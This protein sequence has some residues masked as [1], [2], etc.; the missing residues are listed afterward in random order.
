MKGIIVKFG[1]T[2]LY[3]IIGLL[4]LGLCGE[5]VRA[6]EVELPGEVFFYSPIA[7]SFGQNAVWTNPAALG[8]RQLG[9]VLIF[10]HRDKRLIRDF[11]SV[12]TTRALG[13]AY[14]SIQGG[15]SPDHEEFIFALGGGKRTG[16]GI[17]YRYIR[18]GAGYL[19][20]R[21]LWTASILFQQTRQLS[22][23]ARAENLNRGRINGVRSDIRFVYGAA[24]RAYKDQFTVTFDVDMTQKESFRQ[25]DF[26]T[27]IEL[28]PMRGMFIY[29]DVDNHSRFNLGFRLN[30]RS[31]YVG[32]R[33]EF[34]SSCKS[35]LSTTYVGTVKG[36]QA[37]LIKPKR[38]MLSLG[39]DGELPE[40][41]DIPF[42]GRRP[43]RFF[44]YIA[45]I[46][47]AADDDQIDRLFLHIKTLRCGLGKAEE[48]IEALRYFKSRNK[49]V[50]A[51]LSDPNNLG[52][53]VAST[54]DSVFIPPVSAV[55][56]T[57]LRVELMMYKG[58]L[59]K[60]G[61]ELELE[62]VDEYK[63]AAEPY[64]FEEPTEANR[65]Q[66]NRWLEVMYDD[67]T[68]VIAE[69]RRL[70]LDS[71]RNLIDSAPLTSLNAADAGLVDSLLYLDEAYDALTGSSASYRS[72][73]MS[74]YS[75]Y[76][77]PVFDDTWG[78][79]PT[80]AIVIA[81][82]GITAG[83]SGTRIGEH[84]MIGAVRRCRFDPGIK[85]VLLRINSPGGDALAADLLWHEID[86]LAEKKP[87]VIS[88][89]N[90]AASGGYYI[91]AIE[92][93]ILADKNTITGSIGVF[94]GKINF[95][96][97]YNKIGIYTETIDRGENASMFSTTRPYTEAQREKLKSQLW[98]FYDHFV[99][100]VGDVRPI[101]P[102]S[103][104]ALGRGQV[105]TGREAMANGLI[106]DIGGAWDALENLLNDMGLERSEVDLAVLPEKYYFF[107]N[108]FDLPYLRTAI[109]NWI[110]PG[111][112]AVFLTKDVT[113]GNIF[114]RMPYDIVVE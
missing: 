72:R 13:F 108:P 114:Y 65:R 105:W 5:R 42:F 51:Y 55:K 53:L 8:R 104:N 18:K 30:L 28:R 48:L 91:A 68:S 20:N 99:D 10:T 31:N 43:L 3:C 63:S 107:K 40:N 76:T 56:L 82:G 113:A 29:A 103:V 74:F 79:R 24:L 38:R 70:S 35:Y 50:Y 64:M 100:K 73:G 41:P 52:Y 111:Q 58:L 95:A 25:A 106:D 14:R 80:I 97:L 7:S 2:F 9:S 11:G 44:D 88:M 78:A 32:H 81:D 85:G 19:N 67:F 86:K 36:R 93:P 37:S 54:A 77:Q 96:E 34:E 1:V 71:I 89:G 15:D 59:D 39:L 12:T 22:V 45:G 92:S 23:G 90:V 60:L 61:V 16:V 83:K 21:H 102:D 26:R 27:G 17:S 57:G 6:E 69:N 112:P 101:S 75:Y 87:V 4:C 49:P 94:G 33:M 109:L 84:E 98:R 110:T 46:R 66:V 62:R 47:Q